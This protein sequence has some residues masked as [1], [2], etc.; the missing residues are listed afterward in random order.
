MVQLAM[1]CTGVTEVIVVDDKSMDNT[2]EEDRKQGAI[3]IASTRLGE[4]ASIKDGVLVPK[5]EVLAFI[6]CCC[7][8][9]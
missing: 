2:V 6:R 4:G 3:V 9:Y 8:G 5:N 1:S 7:N